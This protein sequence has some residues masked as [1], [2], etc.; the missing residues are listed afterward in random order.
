MMKIETIALKHGVILIELMI[1][2]AIIG[3]LAAVAIPGYQDF[4]AR[5]Q[6]T[7]SIN[8]MGAVTPVAEF[9]A[10]KGT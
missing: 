10:D 6:V 5:A 9:F 8:L 4:L 2:V 7:E 1:V 3:I